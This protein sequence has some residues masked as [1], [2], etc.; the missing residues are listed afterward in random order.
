[1]TRVLAAALLTVLLLLGGCLAAPTEPGGQ[2]TPP[3]VNTDCP[4]VLTVEEAG[5]AGGERIAYENLSAARQEEFDR[6][7][8][9]GEYEL[10]DSVPET[11]SGPRIVEYEG[12]EYTVSVY[13]C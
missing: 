4:A 6:A 11:W 12:T 13:V 10:G 1:M 8:T 9:R 2:V 3:S 5:A 7:L